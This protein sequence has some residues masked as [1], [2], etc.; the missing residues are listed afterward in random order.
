MI[1]GT[2]IDPDPGVRRRSPRLVVTG[3]NRRGKG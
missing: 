3:M 2:G 1:P